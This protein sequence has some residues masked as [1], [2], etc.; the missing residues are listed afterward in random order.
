MNEANKNSPA[1]KNGIWQAAD[2]LE[3]YQTGTYRHR[4]L[5]RSAVQK[6]SSI[7]AFRRLLPGRLVARPP[8]SI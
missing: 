8:K 1:C 3:L 2:G 4:S 7:V 5:A 6:V